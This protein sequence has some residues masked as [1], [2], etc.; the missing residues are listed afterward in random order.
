MGQSDIWAPVL[1]VTL[2]IG[3]L[4]LFSHFYRKRI[5]CKLRN[6]GNISN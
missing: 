5:A 4:L 3:S 6:L 1:Y 2:L